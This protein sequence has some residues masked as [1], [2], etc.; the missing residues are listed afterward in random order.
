MQNITHFVRK[1]ITTY[2]KKALPRYIA[3]MHD[4]FSVTNY[5]LSLVSARLDVSQGR[6]TIF[7][8]VIDLAINLALDI[9]RTK[10]SSITIQFCGQ[11]GSHQ[12][13]VWH[14]SNQLQEKTVAFQLKFL[15][16][17]RPIRISGASD[18]NLFSD[19]T[20]H[21]SIWFSRS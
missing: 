15:Q 18:K 9:W 10:L 6:P 21:L 7:Q 4:M 11:G 8:Y 16:Q 14:V 5:A 19:V 12:L 1:S 13:C 2:R 3:K 20:Q 17:C